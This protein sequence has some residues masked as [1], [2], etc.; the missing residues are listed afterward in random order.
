MRKLA[1]C[2]LPLK[3]FHILFWHASSAFSAPFNAVTSPLPAQKRNK[4]GPK[5]CLCNFFING[6]WAISSQY[7][8]LKQAASE[9]L[10]R[11]TSK[12]AAIRDRSLC[13]PP[14]IFTHCPFG[15]QNL[16][17]KMIF[18]WGKLDIHLPASV[19][20]NYVQ[21]VVF[22]PFRLLFLTCVMALWT[23]QHE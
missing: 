8:H 7:S 15:L 4:K 21:S 23:A 22:I 19:P 18:N 5:S 9:N 12:S 2:K 11:A 20:A 6:L 17:L 14:V 1:P 3:I 13:Y 10:E 16:I